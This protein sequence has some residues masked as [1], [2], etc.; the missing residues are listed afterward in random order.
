MITRRENAKRASWHRLALLT[1]SVALLFASY[2][3]V[4]QPKYDPPTDDYLS[5]VY[6]DLDVVEASY[7]IEHDNGTYT[8]VMS[9]G[10]SFLIVNEST[11][12]VLLSQNFPIIKED[13]S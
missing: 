6:E 3:F 13:E 11:I 9:N 10:D 7:L 4:I 2:L 8:A 5:G 12:E 1:V